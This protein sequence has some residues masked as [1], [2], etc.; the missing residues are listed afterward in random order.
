MLTLLTELSRIQQ[1]FN[2]P[3]DSFANRIRDL[4]RATANLYMIIRTKFT[5][6]FNHYK[7]T[8]N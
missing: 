2:E 7:H 4:K 3:V 5:L 1:K 8:Y 6:N